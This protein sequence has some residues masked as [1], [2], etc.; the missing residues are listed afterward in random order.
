MKRLALVVAAL[1]LGMLPVVAHAHPQHALGTAGGVAAGMLHP[2]LGLDHLLAMLTVGL[3][4]A[5]LGGP[6]VWALPTGFVGA[7]LVGGFCG[8]AH[9]R[10]LGIETGTAASVVVLGSV[11]GLLL[12]MQALAWVFGY[13]KLFTDDAERA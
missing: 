13:R 1:A 7:M 12:L 3:I 8:M 4:A 10:A 5:R 6:A 2:L 9:G 11:L